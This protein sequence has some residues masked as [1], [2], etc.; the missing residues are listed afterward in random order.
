MF[1]FEDI[2]TTSLIHVP[3]QNVLLLFCKSDG[4]C[5]YHNLGVWRYHITKAQWTRIRGIDF[6]FQ[7]G[8]ALTA[9]ERH[10]VIV[11]GGEFV[12][13]QNG[14]DYKENQNDI[15]VLDIQSEDEYK[16]WGTSLRFPRNEIESVGIEIDGAVSTTDS[17]TILLTSGWVRTLFASDI[18]NEMELPP[19]VVIQMIENY[20]KTQE[21]IHWF[22]T[23]KTYDEET[24]EVVHIQENHY[25]MTLSH[26]LSSRSE[27]VHQTEVE[28]INYWTNA[29][30]RHKHYCLCNRL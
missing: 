14:E 29:C 23:E 20:R 19:L 6:T 12:V 3:S 22:S 8:I 30:K 17:G 18:F 24:D 10:V 7:K 5:Y 1:Q 13:D 15:F 25:A 11:G 21:T 2:H 16:L 27:T 9:D 4:D 28:G 26:I